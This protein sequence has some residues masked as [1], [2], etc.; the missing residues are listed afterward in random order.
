MNSINIAV[1]NKIATNLTPDVH[2]V[3]GNS[4]Y[5]LAFD[6][7]D[8]WSNEANKVARFVYYKGHQSFYKEQAFI[9]NIVNVP[10]LSNI[11]YV[12]VGVY[13]GDLSTTTPARIRCKRSI[14]CGGA[15]E[16][17]T[18]EEKETLQSQLA[19]LR[20]WMQGVKE[21]LDDQV[22]ACVEAYLKENPP[23]GGVD[24]E[25]DHTL[26]LENGILSVN[27]TND[28]EQDNTLPITSAGVF[29]T[30]GNIEALLKTI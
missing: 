14:L 2:V 23:S 5:V 28:M 4:D 9:G 19:D 8:E 26:K 7:D 17:I 3:C 11:D 30:V 20:D 24:F 13:A 10:V 15:E 22:G 21:D 29:A 1:A 12:L 18:D 27:T 6:F 16:Q 25:T